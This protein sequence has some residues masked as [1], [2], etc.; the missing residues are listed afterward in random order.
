MPNSVSLLKLQATRAYGADVVV[1]ETRQ[2][3]EARAAD[4]AK[5]GAA[6]VPP[7]DSDTVICG[8]GTA[9]LE[10]LA[11]APCHV[12]AVFAPIGYIKKKNIYYYFGILEKGVVGCSA[13]R[14]WPARDDPDPQRYL[15][16]SRWLGT[17]P[18]ARC[19]KAVS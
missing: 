6:F 16:A 3:A 11:D 14:G 15:L 18:R 19:G 13:A 1:T 10:A 4:A 7:Y 12:D 5:Q 17:T 8:Q 2:E 9:M